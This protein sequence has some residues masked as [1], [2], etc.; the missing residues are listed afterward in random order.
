[1]T[2]TELSKLAN[3]NRARDLRGV[4]EAGAG[5]IG[6]EMSV[7]DIL[8]ALYFDTMSVDPKSPLDPKRD[9][10]VLSKGHTALALYVVLAEKGFIPK[11]EISTFLQPNSRLN[12]HPNRV[13]IPG[14]ETNTGP[15]GHGLPIGVGMATGA[16]LNGDDWRTFVITGDGEMQEGSNWEA[17]M[18]AA[19]FKLDNLTLIID[20]NRLQQGARL[21]DTNNIAPLVPKLE[22]FGWAVEE[23]DGHDMDQICAALSPD[24]I[25]AGKPKCIVAHTN[26][27]QG[28]S[29]MS[30][31]VA[32]HHKVPNQAQYEQALKE[33]EE[34]SK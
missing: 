7:M 15:L 10:L 19:Q 2:P 30:D 23:I 22:A 20:H 3:R 33:L 11:E 6:G 21:E 1:M 31:N 32:W 29:F 28:I 4:F 26:K 24:T 25:T 13:K 5:H 8:T 34:A 27:G 16:K 12:G 18:A 14:V 17:I 9:R